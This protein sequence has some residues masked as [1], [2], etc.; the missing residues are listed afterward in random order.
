M[1]SDPSLTATAKRDWA[2]SCP[3]D[4]TDY[5]SRDGDYK[6]GSLGGFAQAKEELDGGKR[7]CAST[8]LRI[9]LPFTSVMDLTVASL[10][11]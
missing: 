1:P 2:Q 11:M 7:L 10:A 3:P 6:C 4:L 9:R 5:S 8:T